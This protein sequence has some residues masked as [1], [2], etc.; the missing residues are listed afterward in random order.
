MD[1]LGETLKAILPS[2]KK[3]KKKGAAANPLME[4]VN[5]ELVNPL[6]QLLKD[7]TSTY[8]SVSPAIEVSA[9]VEQLTKD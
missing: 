6:R 7:F 9:R 1:I 4:Q 8:V 5:A 2:S 3:A